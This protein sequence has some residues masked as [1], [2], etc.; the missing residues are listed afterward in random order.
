MKHTIKYVLL[1]DPTALKRARIAATHNRVYDSQK[2][3]KLALG[4]QLLDQH[5]GICFEGPTQLEAVFFF[6]PPQRMSN[7]K[8]PQWHQSRPDV[9]NLLK[10]IEDVIQDCHIVK[11]DCLFCREVI[12]KKYDNR[13]RTEIILTAL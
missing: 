6:K 9:S 5:D 3:C 10:L 1:G 11:D 8:L 7:A 13:P 4:I 2:A 12:E